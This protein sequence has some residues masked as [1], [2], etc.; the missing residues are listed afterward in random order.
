MTSSGSRQT[1]KS[2]GHLRRKR[3]PVGVGVGV[4]L[5]DRATYPIMTLMERQS[6]ELD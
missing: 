4:R 3:K 2:V 1:G 5:P 6:I